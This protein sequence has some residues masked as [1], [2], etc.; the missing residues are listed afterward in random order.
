[1]SLDVELGLRVEIRPLGREALMNVYYTALCIR[2]RAEDLLRPMGLS[3]VQLN[4]LLI[5]AEQAGEDGLSQSRISEMLLVNRANVTS[6][7]DRMERDGLVERRKASDR[8][9]KMVCLTELGR[10]VLERVRPVYMREIS[11]SATLDEDEQRELIRL[12]EKVRAG[13]RHEA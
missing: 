1:M 7:V 11:E 8:R 13:I 12:L 3:D 5:L 4:V 2:K 9:V 6:L 10:G